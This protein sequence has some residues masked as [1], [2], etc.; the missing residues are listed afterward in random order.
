MARA[1]GVAI[2][3]SLVGCFDSHATE[4]GGARRDAPVDWPDGYVPST[5][6]IAPGILRCNA[7]GCEDTCPWTA[8]CYM[9]VPI[10]AGDGFRVGPGVCVESRGFGCACEA[11]EVCV[12]GVTPRTSGLPMF[13]LCADAEHC[14]AARN[15]AGLDEL[16]GCFY[17]DLTPAVTGE[18]P[19][20]S[21]AERPHEALCGRG[22]PCE[23]GSRCGL[24]S[25]TAS[26]GLCQSRAHGTSC[27]VRAGCNSVLPF[28]C[29]GCR[30]CLR[31][32]PS[33]EMAERWES[34]PFQYSLCVPPDVCETLAS[35]YPDRYT[36]PP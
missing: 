26:W 28:E 31:I 12:P 36:C 17:G 10:P 15:A 25:E 8:E 7:P 32:E 18:L 24:A 34:E 35:L 23:D 22:C 19:E 1:A 21:C 13:Y 20:V 4:D 14:V 2:A 3:F 33:P 9:Q 29:E 11:G 30:A 5:C 27:R 16:A 6:E